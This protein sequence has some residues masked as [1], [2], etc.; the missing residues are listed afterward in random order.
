[1]DKKE[2]FVEIPLNAMVVVSVEAEN[3][4]E[5]IKQAIENFDMRIKTESEKGYEIEQWDVYDQ[6]LAGNV[7]YG[8]TY[9]AHAEEM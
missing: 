2:F 7:W 1:M 6:M 3:K 8:I 5:A 9:K 4:E